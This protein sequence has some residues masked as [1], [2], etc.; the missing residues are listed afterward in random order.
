LVSWVR[1]VECGPTSLKQGTYSRALSYS[2]TW[3]RQSWSDS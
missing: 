2:T 3:N 1:L